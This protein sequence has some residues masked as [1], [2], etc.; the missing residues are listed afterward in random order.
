MRKELERSSP[1]GEQNHP[2]PQEYSQFFSRKR[3]I[4]KSPKVQAVRVRSFHQAL[5]ELLLPGGFFPMEFLS[6]LLFQGSP[7]RLSISPQVLGLE[8][9]QFKVDYSGAHPGS[10]RGEYG[11][12]EGVGRSSGK[13]DPGFPA[14]ITSLSKFLP[15]NNPYKSALRNLCLSWNFGS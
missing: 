7:Y 15:Y 10:Y 4:P 9:W 8:C 5:E 14:L 6:G 1:S 11:R 3:D 13:A 12:R 2:K